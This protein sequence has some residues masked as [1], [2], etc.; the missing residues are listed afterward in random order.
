MEIYEKGKQVAHTGKA[1]KV[2]YLTSKYKEISMNKK[3]LTL[4]IET[5]LIDGKMVPICMSFYDGNKA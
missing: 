1:E 2:R 4:D 5:K 3:I